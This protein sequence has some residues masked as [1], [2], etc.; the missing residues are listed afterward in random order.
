MVTECQNICANKC[1]KIRSKEYCSA[2][3]QFCSC[4]NRFESAVMSGIE[5]RN[6]RLPWIEKCFELN[7]AEIVN[8]NAKILC[9]YHR[10]NK[11]L[12]YT[13]ILNWRNHISWLTL[14]V[15]FTN[16]FSALQRIQ[17][18]ELCTENKPFL[19]DVSVSS[20]TCFVNENLQKEI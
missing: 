6:G 1:E 18:A 11:A 8:L 4:I 17:N 3:Y 12:Y 16:S 2:L 19:R 10:E 14:P 9:E 5:P 20:Y 7:S 15:S 13:N